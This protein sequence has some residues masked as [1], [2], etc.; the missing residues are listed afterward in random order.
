M[1]EVF[2]GA[3]LQKRQDFSLCLGTVTGSFNL[4]SKMMELQML[5]KRLL[6]SARFEVFLGVVKQF[7][8]GFRMITSVRSG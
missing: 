3:S 6:F 5:V 1:K 2:K 8:E 4:L 7:I